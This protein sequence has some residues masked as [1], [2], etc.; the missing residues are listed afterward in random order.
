MSV[1]ARI[2]SQIE[3]SGLMITSAC[4]RTAPGC[5][6]HKIDLGAASSGVLDARSDDDTGNIACTDHGFDTGAVVDAYWDGGRRYGMNLTRVDADNVLLD[7]GDGDVLPAQGTS[8]KFC[9]QTD[10]DT[11]FAGDLMKALVAHCDQRACICLKTAGGTVELVLDLVAGEA[12]SWIDDGMAANPIAGDTIAKA[13]LSQANA[14][15][16][17]TIQLGILY[18]STP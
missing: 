18:N 7:S 17:A 1:L 13:T 10:L 11:D 16:A 6:G 12:Q 9:E 8:V 5:I 4:T 2:T 3:I 14:D 15:N